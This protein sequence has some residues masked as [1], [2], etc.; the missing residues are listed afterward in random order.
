[1]YQV[2]EYLVHPGQGVCRVAEI[3]SE[4]RES[5]MLR[6]VGMRNAMLI[7]FPVASEARLRPILSK[8]EA[9]E[10]IGDYPTMDVDD[11]TGRSVS[12]EEEHFKDQ[13]RRG[14]CRDSVRVVKTFR[15]R[16]AAVRRRNKKP[17]VAYERI[18]KQASERSL[19]ELAVAL[20]VTT[21]DVRRL[22]EQQAG[23]DPSLT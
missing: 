18:L 12:L 21:D 17:P 16:I 4:P 3:V 6:P 14:T 23:E 9:Q 1:M 19:L 7:S 2:G 5:Y 20:G 10:L 8:G 22:F 11:F 15:T 13:I